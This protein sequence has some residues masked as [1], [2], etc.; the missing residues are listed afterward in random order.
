MKLKNVKFKIQK[1][2]FASILLT[3]TIPTNLS[4][5]NQR[6]QSIFAQKQLYIQQ[7]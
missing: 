2:A 5:T 1:G 6:S 7:N 4:N 3:Q